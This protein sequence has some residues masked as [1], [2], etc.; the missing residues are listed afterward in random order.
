M[1]KQEWQTKN[2]FTD[3]EMDLITRCLEMFKGTIVSIMER[4]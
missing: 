4:K 1:T 2:G 3:S